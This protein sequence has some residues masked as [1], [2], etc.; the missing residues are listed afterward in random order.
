MNSISRYRYSELYLLI[1]E[2]DWRV[3]TWPIG[4]DLMGITLVEFSFTISRFIPKVIL[5][6]NLF[7]YPAVLFTVFK[8]ITI[9]FAAVSCLT[10]RF[11]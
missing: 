6:F 4:P 5:L 8:F 1:I 10:E 7:K 2:W 3:L 11:S 9:Y